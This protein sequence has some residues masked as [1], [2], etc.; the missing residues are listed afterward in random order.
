M[1]KGYWIANNIVHDADEYARYKAANGAVFARHGAR[2]IV[3]GGTQEAREGDPFP[4]SVVIEF[5]S[6]AQALACYEDPDYQAAKAIR[7]P[8]SQTRL[9]IVEGYDG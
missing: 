1:P 7:E 9:V 2:F 3:R 4:R 8:A 6:Y 5:P